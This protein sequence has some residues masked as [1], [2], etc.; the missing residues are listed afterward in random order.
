MGL[1]DKFKKKEIVKDEKQKAPKQTEVK[2]EVAKKDTV[3]KEVAKKS[4]AKKNIKKVSGDAY[5]ILI[6]PIVSE[7]STVGESINVYTFKVSVNAT[8]VDVK[9]SVR[10]IY[11]VTARK[12]R[13][14]NMEGKKMR[15]GRKF[16][17][18]GDWKKA[19]ITLPKGQSINI[20]EGV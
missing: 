13:M 17:R 1:L 20:H 19:M 6:S 11:G 5:K 10:Q 9:N 16:G 2:V 4:P 18:R 14:I 7:K 3:K 8:K 12:V 15:S